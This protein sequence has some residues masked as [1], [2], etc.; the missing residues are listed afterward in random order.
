MGDIRRVF[1]VDGKPFHGTGVEA[2]TGVVRVLL[3]D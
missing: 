2:D 3:C 1:T